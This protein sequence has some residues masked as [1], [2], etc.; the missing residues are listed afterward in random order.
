[1]LPLGPLHIQIW[2]LMVGL[3][4]IVGYVLARLNFKKKNLPLTHLDNIFLIL[5]GTGII[6]ARLLWVLIDLSY[7]L[8]N[9]V[10][11]FKIWEGGMAFSGGFFLALISLWIYLKKHEL[12]FWEIADSLALPLVAGMAI[13]RFG[14]LLTGLHTGIP[15][16]FGP[17]Y[18]INGVAHLAWPAYA[19]LNWTLAFLILSKISKKN[20][21]IGMLSNMVLIWWGAWRF[22]SD[23]LRSNDVAIG[24]DARIWILTPTQYLALVVIVLILM[25][26]LKLVR[27][28]A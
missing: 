3:G 22:S 25:R 11:I 12:K 14:C 26:S 20:L 7:F 8:E 23:F 24:G 19:I 18:N 15:I 5:V 1:M 17:V 9:P 28:R 10:S 6:G 16:G 4:M 13:G 21:H 27:A 2:G